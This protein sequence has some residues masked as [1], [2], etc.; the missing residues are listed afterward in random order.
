MKVCD[1]CGRRSAVL[2]N[3]Q[4]EF[5]G[6]GLEICPGCRE[7]IETILDV[8]EIKL[9]ELRRYRRR[10]AFLAWWGTPIEEAKPKPQRFSLFRWPPFRKGIER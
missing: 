9:N 5:S 1:K 2:F 4:K 6:G 7:I 3:L 8:V 10:Q